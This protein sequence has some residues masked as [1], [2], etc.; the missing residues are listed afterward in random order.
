[1]RRYDLEHPAITRTLRMGYPF[2]KRAESCS[3]CGEEAAIINKYGVL[4]CRDC[5]AALW[6]SAGFEEDEE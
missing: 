1:M 5:S 3:V 2:P 4:L 6:E